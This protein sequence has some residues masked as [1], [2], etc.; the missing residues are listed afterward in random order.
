MENS[1]IKEYSHQFSNPNSDSKYHS[2]TVYKRVALKTPSFSKFYRNVLSVNEITDLF[3]DI[4]DI[5]GDD[6]GSDKDW[7]PARDQD[8]S[9]SD[10]ETINHKQ[11][12]KK[13]SGNQAIVNENA[14]LRVY[15]DPPVERAEEDTGIGNILI[16]IN[17]IKLKFVVNHPPRPFWA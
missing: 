8:S 17:L 7:R 15:T 13:T 6:S 16:E 9:S 12:R 1:P 2:C 11:D 5:S 10:E 3:D 14:E 4:P